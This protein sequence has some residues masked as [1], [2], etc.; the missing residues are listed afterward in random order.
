[1]VSLSNQVEV[2]SQAEGFHAS[3]LWLTACDLWL[4]MA[5]G[6]QLVASYVLSGKLFRAI[7]L[8]RRYNI[9]S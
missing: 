7:R 2:S 4:L 8:I 3:N 1:M 9:S 5:C 6:L